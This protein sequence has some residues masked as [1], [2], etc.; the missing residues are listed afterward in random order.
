MVFLNHA[1]Q[2]HWLA[3][4]LVGGDCNRDGAGARVKVGDQSVYVST[5]G[6]YLSASDARAHFGLGT[7]TSIDSLEILWPPRV[8]SGTGKSIRDR[9][10]FTNVAVDRYVL[11]Q[12]P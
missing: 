4:K 5:A 12:H 2:H 9:S 7:A 11:I 1:A 8:D 3:V 6:S 10:V